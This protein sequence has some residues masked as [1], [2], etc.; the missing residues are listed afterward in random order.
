MLTITL[1]LIMF[2]SEK[3]TI[4]KNFESI[5]PKHPLPRQYMRGVAQTGHM[6][7]AGLTVPLQIAMQKGGRD[8]AKQT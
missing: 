6:N 1:Y 7:T 8:N 2:I 4:E 3:I 5:L